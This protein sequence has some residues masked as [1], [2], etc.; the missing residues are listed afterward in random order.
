M[1][2]HALLSGANVTN[3]QMN[4]QV[5]CSLDAHLRVEIV[6][7]ARTDL[8]MLAFVEEFSGLVG[9]DNLFKR[10]LLLIR[11]WWVYETASYM[12]CPI[13]H[14]LSDFSLCIMVC[15]IF[16][17]Y[18]AQIGSP[19]QALCLFLTEYSG[20]DGSTHA[21]TLQGIVSF[22]VD[23]TVFE[24]CASESHLVSAQ[25]LDRF[26]GIFNVSSQSSSPTNVGGSG[27]KGGGVEQRVAHMKQRASF[28]H[29]G[30][31]VVHPF[32]T[33]QSETARPLFFELA[34]LLKNEFEHF[35][36]QAAKLSSKSCR[37]V[38]S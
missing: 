20:Y 11:A 29:S 10:S 35:F 24:S 32:N 31:N 26:H 4:Y 38:F 19:L 28:I 30:F 3:D 34:T 5:N 17:Q 33:R 6:V 21:I 15:A 13:K 37:K 8:C 14:Y 1:V 25:I 22:V 36:H 9:Q 7:N 27:A 16:N 18:H 23:G 12:G 2:R